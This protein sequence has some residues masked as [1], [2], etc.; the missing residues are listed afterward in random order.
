[1]RIVV[2]LDAELAERLHA[3]DAAEHQIF[4]ISCRRL[5]LI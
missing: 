4:I 2:C 3:L 5:K 1:M